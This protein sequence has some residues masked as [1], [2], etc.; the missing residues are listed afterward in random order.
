MA[1]HGAGEGFG[2]QTLIESY[3]WEK[4]GDGTVVDVSPFLLLLDNSFR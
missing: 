4:I 1:A 2:V 3:D